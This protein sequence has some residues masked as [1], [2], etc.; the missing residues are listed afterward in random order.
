MFGFF[1]S[2][3]I[4][5]QVLSEFNYCIFSYLKFLHSL[6]FLSWLLRF[7]QIL[8][9]NL[10]SMKEEGF[11]GAKS[12]GCCMWLHADQTGAF[13]Q[14]SPHP[15]SSVCQWFCSGKFTTT[16]THSVS[17]KTSV[18]HCYG[19]LCVSSLAWAG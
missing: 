15:S 16:E 3:I 11:N 2:V 13:C 10:W 1:S 5:I 8:S 6:R 18:L 12:K 19:G 9:V 14:E 17:L 7:D 4:V